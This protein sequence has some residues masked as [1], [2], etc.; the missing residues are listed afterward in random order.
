MNLAVLPTERDTGARGVLAE[1]RGA[2]RGGRR[3]RERRGWGRTREHHSLTV[4]SEAAGPMPM[5]PVVFDRAIWCFKTERGV[6]LR[7][8]YD[9]SLNRR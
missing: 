7:D 1:W 2:E 4:R 5:H 3:E 8:G 6:R 9:N